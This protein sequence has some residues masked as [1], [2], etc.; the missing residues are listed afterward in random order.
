MRRVFITIFLLL[1][2][3]ILSSAEWRRLSRTETK[4]LRNKIAQI[5]ESFVGKKRL[6]VRGRRYNFDC[7]GLILA[8]MKSNNITIF[9]KQAVRTSGSNGVKVIFDT[10]KKYNKIFKD[11]KS[12]EKG[13]F[14][15]FNNTYDKNN[16]RRLDDILTH[17]ALIVDI[18]KDGTLKY[19]HRG[20]KG[21]EYGYINLK[22]RTSHKYKH[23]IINSFLRTKNQ[24]DH[25][26][27]KY[28]SGELFYFFGSIFR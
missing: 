23:K 13:D 10:L 9:E 7:S 15:F 20:S 2:I 22:R 19:V 4:Q 17:I 18:D 28:L 11:F 16:N 6:T 24:K 27:T 26:A 12:A 8:V 14:I 25:P 21:I 1:N 3:L 5:A